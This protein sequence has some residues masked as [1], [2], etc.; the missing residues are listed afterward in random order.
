MF[1]YFLTNDTRQQKL[2]MLVGPKRSGKGTI[3]R[4]IEALLGPDNVVG[5]TLD[6]FSKNFGLQALIGKQLAIIP[7]ARLERR[8]NIAITE[9]LLSISGGDALTIDRKFRDPLTRQLNTRILLL[10]NELPSLKD[11]SGAL[12]SRFIMLRMT[13]S[14]YGKEDIGLTD[15]LLKELPSILNWAIEGWQRLNEYGCF[16]QPSSSAELIAEFEDLSSP[17]HAFI[18]D[19]CEVKPGAEIELDRLFRKWGKWCDEQGRDFHGIKSSFG[20]DLRAAV[21]TLSIS[22]PRRGGKRIRVYSGIGLK[23]DI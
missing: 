23:T 2:F 18:R 5:P 11:A 22:Q 6:S 14:F 16:E 1:G 17:I 4:V 9:R 12:A 3:A 21:P 8:T 20:R 7:D 13:K 19:C 10:S 15:R